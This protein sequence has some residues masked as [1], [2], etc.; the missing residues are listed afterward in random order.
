MTSFKGALNYFFLRSNRSTDRNQELDEKTNQ[1][2]PESKL[3]IYHQILLPSIL[4]FPAIFSV[5]FYMN[6]VYALQI[7]YWGNIHLLI[8]WYPSQYIYFLMN[9]SYFISILC[10]L[11][12]I[13]F[14]L[15]RNTKIFAYLSFL[16]VIIFVIM[17]TIIYF[18]TL[19]AIIVSDIYMIVPSLLGLIYL[20]YWKN[21][22][23][24]NLSIKG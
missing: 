13:I 8:Y 23:E 15:F 12:N 1:K 19:G 11:F 17:P 6:W 16:L 21:I 18:I 10:T 2:P 9:A 24:V 4:T 7:W 3:V 22:N 5:L 20:T 14:I